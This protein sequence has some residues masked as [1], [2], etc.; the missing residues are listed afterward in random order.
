[1][2]LYIFIPTYVFSICMYMIIIPPTGQK[3]RFGSS[4]EFTGI[5][6]SA[7]LGIVLLHLLK[8]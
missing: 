4:G 2:C 6:S 3:Q 7:E 8:K 5:N 1:M